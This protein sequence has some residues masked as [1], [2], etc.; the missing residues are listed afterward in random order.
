MSDLP[1]RLR[2]ING[3]RWQDNAT[4][5]QAAAEL[6]RQREVIET[7]HREYEALEKRVADREN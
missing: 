4:L 6:E 1:D 5:Y 2:N 7:W 3:R